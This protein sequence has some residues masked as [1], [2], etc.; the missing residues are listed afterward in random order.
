M[1]G[2]K[3]AAEHSWHACRATL[4]SS[5]GLMKESGEVIQ[6]FCRWRAA[7]SVREYNHV[8]PDV[9]ADKVAAAMAVD[10]AQAPKGQTHVVTD[11]DDAM[12]VLQAE[13]ND[14]T[15]GSS[16][17]AASPIPT[18]RA[19]AETKDT[20]AAPATALYQRV[21]K[22]PAKGS[23]L[24]VPASTWPTETC[25]ENDGQGWLA[26][27][28]A[29]HGEAVNLCFEAARTNDGRPYENVRLEWQHLQRNVTG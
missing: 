28:V 15:V 9:Y 10:A 2:P 25:P 7:E 21:T 14:L 4:A 29:V 3:K 26:K 5:L 12:A 8:T 1:V 16:S 17:A 6:V 22:P 20:P 13:L 19:H 23:V 27:V 24:L 18:T 11:D